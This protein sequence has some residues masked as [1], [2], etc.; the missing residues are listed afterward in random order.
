MTKAENILKVEKTIK[1][2]KDK[3]N[4]EM[5]AQLEAKLSKMQGEKPKKKPSGGK[6]ECADEI[7]DAL[8]VMQEAIDLMDKGAGVDEK[9][10]VKIFNKLKVNKPQLGKDVIAM[11]ESTRKLKLT[12]IKG[13]EVDMDSSQL[14]EIFWVAYSDL[15]SANNVYLYGGAGTGKTYTSKELAK[16]LNCTLITIN[17]N[18]FTSPLEI[19]GGQTIEGYQ[20]GKLVTAWGN[21]KSDSDGV[22]GGMEDGTNGCLLLLDELPKIDPNTAG[23]LNDA[24]SEVKNRGTIE[25]ARGEKFKMKRFFCIATGNAKLSEES[26]DYVANFRQDLSLQDRFA[27]STYEIFVN[28]KTLSNLMRGYLFIYNFMTNVQR[29]ITSTEGKSRNMDSKAF[30]SIRIMQSLRDS[31]KF[32]YENHKEESKIKTIE[33]GIESFFG[34]FSK[35]QE[36]WIREESKYNDFKGVI[37][38]MEG[39]PLGTDTKEQVEEM[40]AIVKAW[41]NSKESRVI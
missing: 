3:G 21:L 1:R 38:R 37:R 34:L 28:E 11:I 5:V 29:L 41:E 2:Y 20:E 7:T 30:V 9:S 35:S 8:K 32:W 24:L 18:Q 4:K 23:L 10:V 40:E 13:V 19:I 15:Q 31:W 17:C 39:K 36:E 25:N 16:A 6:S 27:G 33:Q 12:P 22:S 26:V 14:P